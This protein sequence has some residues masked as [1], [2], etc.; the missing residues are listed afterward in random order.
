M[1]NAGSH[2]QPRLSPLYSGQPSEST[3]HEE[4]EEEGAPCKQWAH[5]EAPPVDPQ[6]ASK[7]E[8][9]AQLAYARTLL[10]VMMEATMQ[11]ETVVENLE[12]MHQDEDHDE[13]REATASEAV[14]DQQP[15]RRAAD[16][17]FAEEHSKE[18]GQ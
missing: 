9:K 7:V 6:R 10:A 15:E 14:K 2:P 12:Q 4:G 18:P 11:M 16:Q 1:E 8:R 17:D 3:Q 5:G 13:S